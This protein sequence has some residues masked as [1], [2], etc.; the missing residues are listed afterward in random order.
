MR[1][2]LCSVQLMVNQKVRI[3]RDRWVAREPT[4]GL[5][6]ARGRCRLKWVSE[7]MDFRGN[8]D[9][10]KLQQYFLPVD[11]VEILKIRPSPRFGEDFLAWAPERNGIFTVRSAYKLASDEASNHQEHSSSS[12]PDGTRAVWNHIWKSLVPPKVQSFAWRLATDSLANWTNKVKRKL[13]VSPLCPV[14]GREDEDSFHV[15]CSCNHAV[16]LWKLMAKVWNLPSRT[17]LKHVGPDW[18]IHLLAETNEEGR[19]FVMMLFWRIWFVRNELVHHKRPPPMEVSVCFLSSYLSSL[20]A[21]NSNPSDDPIKGK[22]ILDTGLEKSHKRL[23]S[24]VA[25][26]ALWAKP[27]IG[28]VKLNTDASVLGEEAGCGMILRDHEGSIIFSSCRHIYG[29]NDVLEAELL[30]LREG[31]SLAILWSMLPLDIES[32]C[33]QAVQMIVGGSSNKSKFAFIVKE[34]IGIM[35]ERSSCITHSRRCCNLASH[36]LAN[37]GRT[38][39]RPVVWLGSGPEVVRDIIERECNPVNGAE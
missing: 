15:F 17:M 35:E 16:I 25:A 30:A 2:A 12:S 13:E 31:I 7:L 18:F 27:S 3:W 28:R 39:R 9:L 10:E 21:I 6:S 37:F 36:S 14:C 38:Q 34:I 32:D 24:D 22:A 1:R 8:W 11:I 33:L 19:A 5:I 26:D 23:Q 20:S 29:C 4:G